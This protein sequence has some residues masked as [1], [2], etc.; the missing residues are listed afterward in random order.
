MNFFKLFCVLI[1]LTFNNAIAKDKLPSQSSDDINFTSDNLT[2]DEKSGVMTASGNVII[3]SEDR[4]ITAD[5]VVYDKLNDKAVAIGN[6]VLLDKDGTKHESNKVVLTNKFKSLLAIP[7]YSK[8]PSGSSITAKKLTKD[9]LGESIFDEG[10]YTACNCNTKEGETPIWRLESKKITHDPVTKTVFHKHVKMK[11]FFLPV[12]YLPYMSI[13]DWTV[14]RRTGFLTPVYGYSK[15]NRFH[16]KIPYYFAPTS[17]KTWDMTLTSHQKG[18]RGNA[19]Q[20]NFRKNYEKTRL[21]TNIFKGNLDTTKKD[22]DNVFGIN[23]SLSSE[24]GNNW[25]IELEG[26]YSDQ[27]T[28]MRNYGFDSDTK[29]KSFIN[30]KKLNENSFSNIEF[31]NIE[32]LDSGIS[33]SNEPIV[34][35]SI[36]HHIFDSNS[37]YNYD[38]KINAHSVKNDE[39]YDIKRW[40]GSGNFNKSIK[41]KGFKVEGE[42]DLGLDLYS[43]Q[44]RPTTDNNKSKYVNRISS[45]ISVAASKEFYVSNNLLGHSLEPKIQITSRISNDTIDKVPNRDSSEFK[46]DEANLFLNNQYQGRDNIQENS[47]IN[48]GLTSFL[49]TKNYGDLNFFIGQS[50]R[51]DGTNKNIKTTNKDRQSHIINTIDWKL[52]TKYNFSWFSLYNHH[53]FKSDISDFMFKGSTESGFGYAINHSAIKKEFVSGND[54]REELTLGLTKK[55]SDLVT[56]YSRTIDLNNGKEEIIS[57][58]IG[59][60]FAAGYMFQNCLTFSFKYKNS[61]GSQDR[62]ILPEDSIYLTFNFRNLGSYNY[63]PDKIL[64]AITPRLPKQLLGKSN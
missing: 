11:I 38:I 1:L 19:D 17:D 47:R 55:F 16:A 45:G 39:Y 41:Y 46:L 56:S 20:L 22:G 3:I 28:F 29:Y 35:P 52:D 36:N 40:S 14:K 62:T 23:L 27:D 26:K 4:K 42:T 49:V 30:L 53:D 48:M 44:E 51:I 2:V 43:I 32:S 60:E 34:A 31:S 7:L 63:V 57:E 21:E 6:V 13:P 54:D 8:L 33:S 15:R 58:E 64:R 18:K 10:V 24:F 59:I 9:S 37:D 25:N 61:G 5:K 12:Y 50:Q